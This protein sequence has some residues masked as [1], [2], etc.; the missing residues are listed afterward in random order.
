MR[1]KR[2]P[3]PGA[4]RFDAIAS[5]PDQ[6]STRLDSVTGEPA[7]LGFNIIPSTESEPTSRVSGVINLGDEATRVVLLNLTPQAMGALLARQGWADDA[8][9]VSTELL[10]R[11][12]AAAPTYP[13]VG[14]RL[15]PGDG[16]WLPDCGVVYDGDTRGKQDIDIVLTIRYDA[17]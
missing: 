14:I 7:G 5:R 12:F 6:P 3:L 8:A 10:V 16:L 9:V 17:A 4:C 1:F 15:D 2:V 13:L 11:F